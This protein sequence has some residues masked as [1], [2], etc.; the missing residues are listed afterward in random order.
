MKKMS[1]TEKLANYE[2]ALDKLPPEKQFDKIQAVRSGKTL[3]RF[4]S[5]DAPEA[6]VLRFMHKLNEVIYEKMSSFEQ[7]R[8]EY[9]SG[10]FMVAE[11]LFLQADKEGYK[12]AAF[13]L[14]QI[15]T[16]RGDIEAA[17]EWLD[18]A[19]E[20]VRDEERKARILAAKAHI[21][22]LYGNP[23]RAQILYE[24]AGGLQ[25]RDAAFYRGKVKCVQGECERAVREFAKGADADGSG[26]CASAIMRC[27]AERKFRE[28]Q[29]FEVTQKLLRLLIQRGD[30]GMYAELADACAAAGRHEEAAENYVRAVILDVPGTLDYILNYAVTL[31]H[32]DEVLGACR[33]LMSKNPA[34]VSV[35]MRD[36]FLKTK[37]FAD[38]LDCCDA[39]IA[40][41]E[42]GAAQEALLSAIRG[43]GL[44][45]LGVYDRCVKIG[46]RFSRELSA[47]VFSA[48]NPG[49]GADKEFHSGMQ[50]EPD[51][52]DV[53]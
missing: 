32:T 7:G 18:K 47:M 20:N 52:M 40:G 49:L 33:K 22:K 19:M 38:L 39:M 48:Y 37:R 50:M 1:E 8:I 15:Y 53:N 24:K 16:G 27:A 41:G 26:R 35:I 44:E 9:E 21:S 28:M 42:R 5:A 30:I 13:Y 12:D 51:W 25:T 34:R 29:D 3:R 4:L 17:A 23:G 43:G 6:L 46:K 2:C 45:F 31:G 11:Q 14:G 10:Q 36:I